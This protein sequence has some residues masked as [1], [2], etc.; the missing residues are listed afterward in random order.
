MFECYYDDVP[1][2]ALGILVGFEDAGRDEGET[3]VVGKGDDFRPVDVSNWYLPVVGVI[4]KERVDAR[5]FRGR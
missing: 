3:S 5:Y 1:F 2:L 4:A